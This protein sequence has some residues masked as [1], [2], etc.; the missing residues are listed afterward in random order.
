MAATRS[1]LG[2]LGSP[3]AGVGRR[4]PDERV[5]RTVVGATGSLAYCLQD[6]ALPAGCSVVGEA[7]V[8]RCD[9]ANWTVEELLPLVLMGRATPLAVVIVRPGSADAVVCLG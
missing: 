4:G 6:A 1:S 9:F 8:R 5:E 7:P 3:P 2:G